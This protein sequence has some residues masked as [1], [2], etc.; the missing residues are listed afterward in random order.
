MRREAE[1]D[2]HRLEDWEPQAK[3]RRLTGKQRAPFGMFGKPQ[4]ES[5]DAEPILL[6]NADGHVLM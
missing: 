1:E 2:A 6:E 5:Q 3:R 4:V